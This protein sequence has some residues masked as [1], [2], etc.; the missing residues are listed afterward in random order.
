[1]I[2]RVK[3][4]NMGS[5][6]LALGALVPLLVLPGLAAANPAKQYVLKHPKHE[7]CKAR[8]VKRVETVKTREHGRAVK[9]RETLCVYVAPTKAPITTTT[10]A[11][12]ST[13]TVPAPIP[14]TPTTP[15]PART[16]TLH[17]HLDPSFVQSPTN[18]LAVT[19]HY[20]ASAT[21]G[22]ENEPNLPGG[23]LNLYSDGLLACSINVGGSIT[24]G[25]CPITYTATGPQTIIVT[26]SSG[27]T[28]VTETSIEDIEPF[29]TQ[30]TL[31]IVSQECKIINQTHSCEYK[32]QP[33]VRDQE[34]LVP[35]I[36]TDSLCITVGLPDVAGGS[37]PTSNDKIIHL[38]VVE[39]TEPHECVFSREA[40]PSTLVVKGSCSTL[41]M[42]A[43]FPGAVGWL[44]SESDSIPLEA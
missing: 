43:S 22:S 6:L 10:S 31:T 34:S 25:E 24:G 28:S 44:P 12:P 42:S 33:S 16:V 14:S 15:A 21:V 26:Y 23:I 38:Q 20:S 1:M 4:C 8:Y 30:T 7:R 9:V 17:A 27:A 39:E 19:Y 41:S 29:A 35:A 13:S 2:C 5:K 36:C 32:I 11:T 40:E 3:L 18:P 37:Y